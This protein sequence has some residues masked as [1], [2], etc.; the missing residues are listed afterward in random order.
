MSYYPIEDGPGRPSRSLLRT[1]LSA[2]G[3][4]RLYDP[5]EYLIKLVRVRRLTERERVA[6]SEDPDP[7]VREVATEVGKVANE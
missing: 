3:V 6:Y 5:L 1:Q 7:L 4:G 2:Y